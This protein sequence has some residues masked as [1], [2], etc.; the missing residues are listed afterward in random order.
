VGLNRP[1]LNGIVNRIA[2][3]GIELEG[4][5]DAPVRGFDVIRDGSVV[6]E[7]QRPRNII[8]PET[9]LIVGL[10]TP[11][12]MPAYGIGEIVSPKL[13]VDQITDFMMRAYPQHVNDTCGLHVHMSFHNKL[14]Y[15]R[16]M[17]QDYMDFVIDELR[18]FGNRMNIPREHM[19]WNRLDPDHPWTRQHCAH[20]FLA[21]KQ[22]LVKRKDFQSRGTEHSRYTFINYCEAQHHTVECRG[23]PMF[24]TMEEGLAAVMAT[25]DATNRYLSKIRLKESKIAVGIEA[26]P[27]VIEEVG[28]FV[29]P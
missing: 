20:Q 23:L 29:R 6:F 22:V 5:W 15:S 17:R 8:N 24:A 21:D 2:F 26:L 11:P 13:T 28:T 9:G 16:L 19:F 27:E 25:L 4:G 10:T 14:N 12:P 3:V 18:A 7:R 1:L